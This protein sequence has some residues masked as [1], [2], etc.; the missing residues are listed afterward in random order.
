[1]QYTYNKIYQTQPNNLFNLLAYLPSYKQCLLNLHIQPVFLNFKFYFQFSKVQN[2]KARSEI[3]CHL[4]LSLT[5][6]FSISFSLYFL[7]CSS[8][9]KNMGKKAELDLRVVD[10]IFQ[11]HTFIC[12]KIHLLQAFT[13]SQKHV[14]PTSC[15]V[16][17]IL[18]WPTKTRTEQK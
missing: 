10:K 12:R 18:N 9:K 4:F 5:L 16:C 8:N 14:A 2:I 13:D 17:F 15:A 7:I 1:M 3:L 6:P 11:H